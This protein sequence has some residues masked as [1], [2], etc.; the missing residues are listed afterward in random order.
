MIQKVVTALEIF[1]TFLLQTTLFPSIS[2]ASV[3]P[4]LLLI[5]TVSNGFMRGKKAGLFTGFF[6]GLMIDIFYS[7][8]LGFY[9]LVYMYIGFLNGMLFKVYYDDDVKVPMVLVAISDLVYGLAIYGFQF[10]LRGRTQIFYYFWHIIIPEMVYTT[11][12][13]LIVYRIYYRINNL[14]AGNEKEGQ[15]LPWLKK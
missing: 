15:R 2:V 11:L 10:L 9:A 8:L 3:V 5:L 4:N 13:T 12:M 7:D 14:A 6:S 1:I